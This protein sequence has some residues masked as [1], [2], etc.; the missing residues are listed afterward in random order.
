[1]EYLATK[2]WDEEISNIANE[3]INGIEDTLSQLPNNRIDFE[4]PLKDATGSTIK[5]IELANTK[6]YGDDVYMTT[7]DCKDSLLREEPIN[8]LMDIAWYI[9]YNVI[10]SSK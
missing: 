2:Y 9:N 1:M 10:K 4:K 7:D 8:I 5:F 3:I 6:E